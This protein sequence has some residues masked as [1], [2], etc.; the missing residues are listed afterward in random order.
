M[1]KP[2]SIRAPGLL[3][4]AACLLIGLMA[5]VERGQAKQA[6]GALHVKSNEIG[7]VVASS[8]GPEA[9]VWVI[10][11]TTDLPTKYVKIVV[12]DDQGR[13]LIPELPKA[14][15]KVWVRGYGLVDSNAVQSAPGK[16]VD[17]K[18]SVAPDAKA[19][20]QYYPSNYWYALLQLPPK[21]DFP[22]TGATGN[23][24]S[25]NVKDQAEW[26]DNAKVN[27]CEA[28]HQLGD[29][30]TREIPAS[31][32]H[33]DSSTAAW[34]RRISSAQAGVEMN[35]FLTRWYG[36]HRAIAMFADW[37]DRIAAG[38]YPTEAPPRPDGVERNIVVTEWD[39][40]TPKEYFH[41]LMGT[42]RR[43]PTVNANGLLYGM[44]EE[45]NDLLT[46][47]DPIHNTTGEIPIP[48]TE[49]TPYA[50][51][52]DMSDPSPYWGDE[53]IWTSKANAH[54]NE[55]DS[56]GRLWFTDVTKPRDNPAYCKQG[57]SNL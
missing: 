24:I 14:N 51:Q 8:K 12:T 28:C 25:P 18:A 9:G 35:T 29:K 46:Y 32:G 38:E 22:G 21:S 10:A 3:L 15:Y 55:M 44:H 48:V 34:A 31:L 47:L 20:A 37:T 19:A 30:A 42:D 39:W 50:A 49:G 23:G 56:K 27:S 53:K 16:T 6:G 57:S 36:R 11:E 7:G 26:I 13:Y 5:W 2:S 40:G 52:Q 17:L 33:F 54:S 1:Q 45:A 41:D 4:V 43:N